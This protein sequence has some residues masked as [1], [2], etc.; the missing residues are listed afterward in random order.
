MIATKNVVTR[1]VLCSSKKNYDFIV[2][3]LYI[4]SQKAFVN[5]VLSKIQKL[6][7]GNTDSQ[8]EYVAT[9]VNKS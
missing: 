1:R 3:L 9:N 6:D 7:A 5:Q 4:L 8:I 2:V